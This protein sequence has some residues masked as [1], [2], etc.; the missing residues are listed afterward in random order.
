[1]DG[2]NRELTIVEDVPKAEVGALHLLGFSHSTH[3]E[4]EAERNSGIMY[5]VIVV[6]LGLNLG[7]HFCHHAVP[8]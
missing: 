4:T 2:G 1:M 3:E 5:P 8:V 7:A 6:Q